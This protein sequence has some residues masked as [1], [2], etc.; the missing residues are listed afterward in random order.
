MSRSEI[1]TGDVPEPDLS[2]FQLRILAIVAEEARYGLA[3]KR[4][5]ESYYGEE[6]NHGRLYPNLDELVGAGYVEKSELDKRTNEYAITDTGRQ[7][8][9]EDVEWIVEK[10]GRELVDST[11]Q[12]RADG[13]GGDD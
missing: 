1:E 5:L 9:L 3:V 6:I 8:L 10:L 13:E 11:P 4:E 2:D 7:V 12:V